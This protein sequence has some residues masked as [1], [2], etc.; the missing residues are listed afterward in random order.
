[1][2]GEGEPNCP[3]T[4]G[5]APAGAG[6][7]PSTSEGLVRLEERIASLHTHM[8]QASH[9]RGC[10]CAA[11]LQHHSRGTDALSRQQVGARLRRSLVGI[12]CAARRRGWR[13]GH[14]SPIGLATP[15][16][17]PDDSADGLPPDV[18]RDVIYPCLRIDEAVGSARPIS[19]AHG[20]QLVDEAFVLRRIAKHLSRHSLTGL[21]DVDRTAA[22][23]T[24][25]A[26]PTPAPPTSSSS[27]APTLGGDAGCGDGGHQ[28]HFGYLCRCCYA[29]EHGGAV[30][31]EWP[32]FI[33][34]ADIYNLT[35]ST[36]LPLV[37]SAEWMAAHLPTKG[38]FHTMPLALRQ[39]STFGH[40][41]NYQGTSLALTKVDD[42]DGDEGDGGRRYLIGSGDYAWDFETVSLSDLPA[43]H[44]YRRT[45]DPHNPPIRYGDVGD[46]LFPSF[47]AFMKRMVLVDWYSQEGVD[48]KRAIHATV[49]DGD[50]RYQ[51]LLTE[52]I[53]GHTTIDFICE[54]EGEDERLRLIILKGMKE[55]DA[56]AAHL[57]LIDCNINLYTT[58]AK[59]EGQERLADRYPI[60]M[61]LARPLLTKNGLAH[62][63]PH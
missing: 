39:Y 16:Q 4:Q 2:S 20:S 37:M 32:D 48:E 29:L 57:Y 54:E 13:Q 50:E 56:I 17:P 11:A 51:R 8:D 3:R 12:R 25:A 9:T 41:L 52:P 62:L 42:A 1:M 10:R 63:I 5:G 45:Y 6:G 34:L 23:T 36:G 18:C 30:W 15:K 38:D 43:G 28:S 33:R 35:P 49:A 24:D 14:H 7:T 47:T 59:I 26:A 60:A 55:G 21:I 58:E 53:N 40:L 22:D 27:D 44:P 19:R 46:S 31:C 61:S